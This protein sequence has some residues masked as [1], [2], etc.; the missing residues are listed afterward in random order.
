MKIISTVM[1]I[2]WILMIISI[3]SIIAIIIIMVFQGGTIINRVLSRAQQQTIWSTKV[4]AGKISHSLELESGSGE[5]LMANDSR[6]GRWKWR[7]RT[8]GWL[9]G[10]PKLMQKWKYKW[11]TVKIGQQTYN[12]IKMCMVGLWS[13]WLYKGVLLRLS[14]ADKFSIKSLCGY[15]I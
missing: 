15:R 7:E 12:N 2:L 9:R 1:V 13:A 6:K 4:C 3:I 14:W 11:Q 8:T 10:F 5:Q